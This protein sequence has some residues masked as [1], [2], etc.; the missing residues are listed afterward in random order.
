MEGSRLGG[1]VR[2]LRRRQGLTQARMAERLQ[3][4]A[5][6]LNLIENDKRPLTAPL[7]LRL[8]Q[9]FD[10]DPSEFSADGD[11]RLVG[12][13]MEVF[14]D[15]LF[16]NA[17]TSNHEIRELVSRL[18]AVGNAILVLYRAYQS[19][20]EQMQNP[21][22]RVDD[23]LDSGYARLPSDEVTAFAQRQRNYFPT[24]EQAAEEVSR[25]VDRHQE[26]EGLV[27][28][29]EEV[30]GTVQ[31][32]QD[33]SFGGA[34]R[35]YD[36]DARRLSLSE[37][38]A[39]R[40]RRFHLGVQLGLLYANDQLHELTDNPLL[41]TNESR[42]LARM[43][44]AGY[45]AGAVLMPY[46]R[47]LTA[48]L[49][50]RYDIELLGHRFRASFEQV[51]HRL[52]S[53]HRPGAA[54][55]PFHFVKI[56]SAGNISKQFSASGMR[57]ARFGGACPRWNVTRAFLRP[58][59]LSTQVS[60]MPDGSTYFCIARTMKRRYGGFRAPTTVYAVGLGCRIEDA[61]HIVYADGIDL[62][63]AGDVT[64]PVG[65]TCRLCE[66]PDCDQRAFPSL[67]HPLRLDE[68]VRGVG[69]YA[70]VHE[71]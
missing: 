17:A 19:A 47:F 5:S 7:L 9:A 64:V 37:V 57:F 20:R 11:A 42:T 27:R 60:T 21:H 63:R 18:P 12:D 33:G 61:A 39:P 1:K 36:P 55:V 50:T 15:S 25:R 8:L 23:P 67:E 69:F 16:E 41:T 26:W 59:D 49:D 29:F 56:D 34:V 40:S 68:N 51:C 46:Q 14:G 53:L 2:A 52:C 28:A 13:L 71:T 62:E 43:V 35:H 24:L 6:Y 65:V 70:S 66:R 32:V 58:N 44:L 31:I 22:Q 4:S 54:G 3:I 10:L 48:A 38:L 45:F 30:G